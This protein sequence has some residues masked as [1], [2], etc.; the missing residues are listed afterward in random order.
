MSEVGPVAAAFSERLAELRQL[1]MLRADG[2]A[3]KETF[4]VCSVLGHSRQRRS[5]AEKDSPKRQQSKRRPA[6]ATPQTRP[7]ACTRKT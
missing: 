7:R 6:D 4:V 3:D 5:S 2:E 1:V